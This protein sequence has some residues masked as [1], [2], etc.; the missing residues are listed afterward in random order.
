MSNIIKTIA[1]EMIWT[2]VYMTVFFAFAYF[3]SLFL[4]VI[5]N[6]VFESLSVETLSAAIGITV[7]LLVGAI[8]IIAV[9]KGVFWTPIT[10]LVFIPVII[11]GIV[12]AIINKTTYSFD[13]RTPSE[14]IK[15]KGSF[16]AEAYMKKI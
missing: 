10:V 14:N 16:I 5:A 9:F 1:V 2:L 7:F 15:W 3:I 12:R 11:S 8:E 13:T 6:V 4:V